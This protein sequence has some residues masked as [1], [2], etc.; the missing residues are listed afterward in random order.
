MVCFFDLPIEI[1]D[2]IYKICAGENGR[3]NSTPQWYDRFAKR[4]SANVA[5]RHA[6]KQTRV[7]YDRYLCTMT[8]LV[9][10][11]SG[12]SLANDSAKTILIELH[13]NDGLSDRACHDEMADLVPKHYK[14]GNGT[15]GFSKAAVRNET[16]VRMK[17]R[18]MEVWMQKFRTAVATHAPN[19][20]IDATYAYCFNGCCR[21]IWELQRMAKD[22]YDVDEVKTTNGGPI[23]ANIAMCQGRSIEFEGVQ[24]PT[25][26]SRLLNVFRL[27]SGHGSTPKE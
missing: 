16:H 1:R 17:A 2:G 6:S 7:E 13:Y 8:W 19:V 20:R 11:G 27:V 10:P 15:H 25:E 9:T 26:A 22:E 4:D 12:P 5:L 18:I 21:L 24:A 14:D 3:V 23:R